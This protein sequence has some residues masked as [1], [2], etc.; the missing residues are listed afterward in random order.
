MN[1]DIIKNVEF[2]SGLNINPIPLEFTNALTTTKWLCEMQSKLT[3]I[4]GAVNVWYDTLMND[5]ENNGVLYQKLLEHFDSE[6]LVEL[7]TVNSLILAIQQQINLDPKLTMSLSPSQVLYRIG[8]TING[9]VLNFNVIQGSKPIVKAEIYKNGVLLTTINTITNGINSY[10]DGNIISS[11]TEYYIKIYD[12]TT[13][14]TSNTI[15]YKFVNNVYV[16]SIN[17]VAITEILIKGLTS[18][19]TLKDTIINSF[20]P[21]NQKIIISYPAEY[22][23][24]TKIYD[25]NGLQLLNSF[26][27]STITM[28]MP[29]GALKLYNIYA[30]DK[31]ATVTNYNIQFTF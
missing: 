5:L 27:L 22:G 31:L 1:N 24:L 2:L 15:A 20:S 14:I 10:T 19:K 4:A 21:T 11:N 8:E 7:N 12:A 3:S 13:V 23:L 28:T 30:L 17:D 16:G 26:V 29:D 25:S 6:F 18:L 9:A